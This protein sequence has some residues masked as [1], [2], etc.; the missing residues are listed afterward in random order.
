MNITGNNS[1]ELGFDS[2]QALDYLTY[3][4]K[5]ATINLSEMLSSIGLNASLR[6]TSV[7][8]LFL[9]AGIIYIGIKLTQPV[10][11]WILII[12]SALLILGLIIPW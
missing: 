2:N 10:L 5:Q 3:L 4:S 12:L 11:K 9:S 8:L 6:W 1:I 7:L